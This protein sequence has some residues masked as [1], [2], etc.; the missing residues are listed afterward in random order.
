MDTTYIPKKRIV[1]VG[2]GFAGLN[3]IK[4][5]DKKRF[6]IT[7]IDRNNYH[8]FPPLF[9]QVASGG[10]EP[11]SI[12]FPFRRETRRKN[13]KGVR[14]RMG[15]VT[16]IDYSRR[17][18]HTNDGDVPYDSLIIAAGTTNNFFGNPDLVEEVYTLKST[19]EAIR[20]RDEIL[21]RMEAASNTTDRDERRKLL[22]FVVI[23][24][25][26]TGVEIAGALGEVKRYIITREYPELDPDDMSVTLLEGA[27]RL[28][29]AMNERSS[30]KAKEYLERL[31]VEVKLGKLMQSYE[32]G[33]VTLNDSTTLT[34]GMVVWTAGITGEG[35]ESV[36]EEPKRGRGNRI[37]VDEYNRVPGFD[38]VYAVGDISICPTDQHPNG[39]PQ[40]AQVAIQQSKL[41]AKQLNK[42]EFSQKFSYND[43][44][45]MA[46]VG[47]NLA[48]VELGKLKFGG[49]TAWFIWMFVHLM[50]LLGMRNKINVLINWTWAYFTFNSSLRLLFRLP[51]NPLRRHAVTEEFEIE[52]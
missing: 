1:I 9:Y 50:S 25:G 12:S 4:T 41:L 2:G 52:K 43:M 46:T 5:L 27:P 24:G 44:G 39:M 20:C 16:K 21:A 51:V 17:I 22:S 47:R 23:G 15:N 18:V 48:V 37:I 14:Y 29:Q 35:F 49:R 31:M 38:D 3:L 36:G 42:G 7:L 33:V 10:L 40:L 26:P 32:D 11:G 34:G 8:C 45:T 13:V 6:D 19:P 30:D 28:L